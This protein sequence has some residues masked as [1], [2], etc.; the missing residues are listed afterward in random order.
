M[1]RTR[2]TRR[3]AGKAPAG[4]GT[5]A[6]RAGGARRAGVAVRR[7]W[8]WVDLPDEALLDVRLCDLEVDTHQ[9]KIPAALARLDAE[10]A[11]RGLRFRPHCWLA[12]DWF[13]PDGVP[14]IA[15]PFYLAHPRLERLERRMMHEVEGGNARWLQRILRHEAG[16]AFDTAYRLRRRKRW[17]EV[18]G[19]ASV[20]Y[21]TSYVP[22]PGSRRYVL[23]LGHWYAQ[24]H[25][26]EDFAETFAVWLAPNSTWRSDYVDWP[27]LRKLA[28]VDALMDEIHDRPPPV[29]SRR[30]VEPLGSNRCTL[31]EYYVR[32]R[33]Y[34]ENTE[35]NRYDA[36]LCRV[37][38]PH[39]AYP[40]RPLAATFLRQVRPQFQRLLIRR[41]RLHPYLVH[42]VMRI[43]IQ[44][45]REL[46]LCVHRPVRRAKREA[47]GVLERILFD[48]IRRGRERYAL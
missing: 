35:T 48:S 11:R 41:S 26:T 29:H 24:S 5:K 46:D 16:H 43:V 27:A 15:I 38:A 4:K 10:L 9:G 14:G 45:S 37:W 40:H 3:K 7:R 23:H 13:S 28:Y 36:R 31:G 42:N 19:A 6:R 22:R 12:E 32:K 39:A 25:P 17:R 30:F 20:P 44:R 18:F 1:V 33:R 8:W 34:Y 21:P 2:K 47:L